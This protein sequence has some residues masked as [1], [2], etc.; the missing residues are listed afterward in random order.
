MAFSQQSKAG[1]GKPFFNN[2]SVLCCCNDDHCKAGH[3]VRMSGY[4]LV[5]WNIEDKPLQH[6][7]GRFW[8]RDKWLYV[9]DL[10]IIS[11]GVG[12]NQSCFRLS[13][14]ADFKNRCPQ[15][16]ANGKTHS[17]K[18]KTYQK[19]SVCVQGSHHAHR[20]VFGILKSWSQ[21]NVDPFSTIFGCLRRVSE[22]P[23]T[24]CKLCRR[25]GSI[26]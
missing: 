26:N 4:P 16:V 11:K 13:S 23:K 8:R 5:S 7:K 24:C 15:H 3:N 9:D 18:C 6:R 1:P 2:Y 17:L 22:G 10:N 21:C 12:L 19:R 25:G 14:H 20:S